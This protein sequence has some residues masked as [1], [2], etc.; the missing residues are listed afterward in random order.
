LF[1]YLL[2][3]L[4]LGDLIRFIPFP[5]IG[6]FLAG[7]GWLLGLGAFQAMLNQP[8][9]LAVLPT[10]LQPDRLLRW[11]PGVVFAAV[12]FA[13]LRRANHYLILPLGLLGGIGLFY[14]ALW[15]TQTSLT[16]AS[17]QGLLLTL[18]ATGQLWQPPQLQQLSQISFGTI[19]EHLGSMATIALLTST[20][21]LLNAVSLELA[22]ERVVDLNHELRVLGI[23]NGVISLFGGVV[24]CNTLS[25]SVLTHRVGAKSPL[26]GLT[27]AAMIGAVL[28]F[29]PAFFS[30]FPRAVVGGLLLLLA[31]EL[32][33]EWGVDARRK[34][35][36]AD[37]GIVLAILVTSATVGFLEAVAV[38][39]AIALV[40]FVLN[41]SRTPVIRHSLS[42]AT[43]QSHAARPATQ[44]QLLRQEGGQIVVFVLQGFLFF[45]TANRLLDQVQLAV[46]QGKAD[47]DEDGDSSALSFVVLDFRL[48]HGIDPSAAVSFLK[49]KQLA[50]RQSFSLVFTDLSPVTR[51]QLQQVGCLE[52]EDSVCIEAPDRDRAL[53]WC[54]DQLLETI[55]VRRRRSL[56]LPLQLED[57]FSHPDHVPTFMRYLEEEDLDAGE[58]LFTQGEAA[59]T[60][61]FIEMGEV[62][63]WVT[64]KGRTRRLQSLGDGNLVGVID[65][66]LDVP[67]RSSAV[68]DAL[69]TLQCLSRASLEQM[70]RDHPEV[71]ADFQEFVIRLLSDRLFQAYEEVSDLL[72]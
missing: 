42:G 38:G 48:T 41:Y 40:L 35:P 69:T 9:T 65:F 13:I 12:L 1:L 3:R 8:L 51:R 66:Y 29:G 19:I 16:E 11:I 61:Y 58:T 32:L 17:N 60:M 24:S 31:L 39:L 45:G 10:L 26:P 54:E 30:V 44:L 6:G 22:T 18:P 25:E 34:L 15:L 62:T 59:S 63:L 70:R 23:A 28:L 43:H 56:P 33:V 5:V 71:A 14:G 27:A 20:A 67:Y 64:G 21:L 36:L 50:Q 53:Q 7:T 47:S 52:P 72:Q 46:Q 55:P 4:R 37:Y 49:L 2:G 57:L 68:A